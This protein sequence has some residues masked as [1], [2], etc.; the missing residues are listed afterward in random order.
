MLKPVKTEEEYNDTLTRAYKL[1]L[2]ANSV[3]L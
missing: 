2:P 3:Q 1:L